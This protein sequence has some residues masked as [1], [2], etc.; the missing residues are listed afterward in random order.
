[1]MTLLI[2]KQAKLKQI[3]VVGSGVFGGILNMPL[4]VSA[5]CR[6][7]SVCTWGH[8]RPHMHAC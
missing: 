6:C 2:T 8:G 4:V 1:M 3:V 7:I 5:H